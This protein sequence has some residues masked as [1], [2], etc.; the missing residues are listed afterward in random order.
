MIKRADLTVFIHLFEVF[1]ISMNKALKKAF[2]IPSLSAR[3]VWVN[4]GLPRKCYILTRHHMHISD[5][6][7][8]ANDIHL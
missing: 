8:S 6:E 3:I 7:L 5:F 4:N 1:E 2:S